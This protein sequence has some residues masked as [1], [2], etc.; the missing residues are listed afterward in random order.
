LLLSGFRIYRISV[1]ILKQ[2]DN[3]CFLNTDAKGTPFS[4]FHYIVWNRAIDLASENGQ[5]IF[6]H[7][8]GTCAAAPYL[9]QSFSIAPIGSVLDKPVFLAYAQRTVGTARIYRR[10]KALTSTTI[11]LLAQMILNTTFPSSTSSLPTT[12]SINYK[13]T[14]CHV[15]QTSEIQK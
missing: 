1:L 3:I 4:F 5:R 13:T 15:Y 2:I 7:E 10:S 6:R 14:Y 9:G 8:T 11:L 12:F